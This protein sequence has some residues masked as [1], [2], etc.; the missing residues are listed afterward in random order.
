MSRIVSKQVEAVITM[1][2][3]KRKQVNSC[4]NTQGLVLEPQC[5]INQKKFQRNIKMQLSD[6]IKVLKQNGVM[7]EKWNSRINCMNWTSIPLN[8]S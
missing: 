5:G 8:C 7:Y 3:L 1:D 2:A 4:R 6:L